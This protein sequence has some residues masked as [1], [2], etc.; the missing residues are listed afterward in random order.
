MKTCQVQ[1]KKLSVG[2]ILTHTQPWHGFDA[3]CQSSGTCGQMFRNYPLAHQCPANAS[4][5]VRFIISPVSVADWLLLPPA[6]HRKWSKNS[7]VRDVVRA[8]GRMNRKGNRTRFKNV[9]RI[10]D[11]SLS[12]LFVVQNVGNGGSKYLLEVKKDCQWF[13]HVT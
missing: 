9:F 5:Y 7:K 13:D 3:V 6:C 12:C 8:G 4:G 1:N 11:G 2:E 10:K